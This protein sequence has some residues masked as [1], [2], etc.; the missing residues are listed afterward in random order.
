MLTIG[1]IILMIPLIAA[2]DT[3]DE[4]RRR[5]AALSQ[6]SKNIRKPARRRTSK[7]RIN[8]ARSSGSFQ[9]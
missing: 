3:Y 6:R 1:T 7:P 4:L 2:L 5:R 9:R 8:R